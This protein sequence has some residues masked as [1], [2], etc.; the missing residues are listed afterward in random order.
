MLKIY[1][2]IIKNKP[3]FYLTEQFKINRKVKKIQVYLGKNIPKNLQKYYLQMAE[4]EKGL[5][6]DQI[7]N[8]FSVD[9]VFNQEQIL[10]IENYK[11]DF[12]YQ[13]LL[14]S[15]FQRDRLWTRYA[16]Q[17]IFE[18]NAIE[19]SRLSAKDVNAIINKKSIG[20]LVERREIKE[21]QNSI[22]AFQIIRG[23]EFQLNQHQIIS[24]HKL[25]VD[26]LG[27]NSG[28]KKV[29]VV[30]N[31]K[32]TTAVGNVREEMNKLL[33]WYRTNKTT[34]QHPLELAADFHQRF[35]QIHPFEDGNGRIG[36]LLFNWIL[37]Q[38][39]YPPILFLYQ[40]R[41]AYFNCLDQADEGR[42]NNWHWFCLKVYKNSIK[43][44]LNN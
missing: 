4:K 7:E 27:I 11:I 24:L 12:K 22:K 2:K 38:F 34:K 28:Y 1:Q 36:R 18:S 33:K 41:R 14:L 29:G 42:K 37:L 40:N 13:L 44:L 21:V 39:G 25:L 15:D 30:V 8:S 26:S 5:V 9:R 19:G 16:V 17:F 6:Q 43:W 10:K 3:Y 23:K 35:E 32:H 31:N 20:K